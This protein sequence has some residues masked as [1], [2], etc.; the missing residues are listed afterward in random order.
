VIPTDSADADTRGSERG[1]AG[2]GDTGAKLQ[3]HHDYCYVCGPNNP[4]AAD[5]TLRCN[6][7]QVIG[8]VKLDHRHQGVPGLAHGGVIAA[9]VDEIAGSLLIAHSLRFVTARLDVEYIAPVPIDQPLSLTA[10]L[11]Q[12]HG[13]KHTVITEIRSGTVLLATGRAL[14]I[15]VPIDHF[16][17]LG[18]PRG[19]FPHFGL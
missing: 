9:I 7:N 13:R 2:D 11:D 14:F 4:A 10:W 8:E 6:T 15:T 3:P 5:I 19:A 18:I 12:A 17:S 16:T 1:G